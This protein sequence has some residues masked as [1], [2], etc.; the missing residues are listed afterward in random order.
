M[1]E[2]T[3]RMD[4]NRPAVQSALSAAAQ[5]QSDENFEQFV[6]DLIMAACIA[7]EIATVDSIDG[8]ISM[9][10]AALPNAKKAA[11]W[12]EAQSD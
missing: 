2:V 1:E 12:H 4:P 8:Y 7:G 10:E 11:A 6:A 3:V 5:Y 9:I